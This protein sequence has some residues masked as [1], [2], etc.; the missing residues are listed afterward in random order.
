M[1]AHIDLEDDTPATGVAETELENEMEEIMK[2]VE[3]AKSMND[4]LRV[5]KHTQGELLK[6][7]DKDMDKL[8]ATMTTAKEARKAVGAR[9]MEHQMNLMDMLE[10]CQEQ[11]IDYTEAKALDQAQVGRGG[12]ASNMGRMAKA[13]KTK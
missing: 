9:F 13:L 6:K 12:T 7:L 5:H 1:P 11:G 10:L 3:K 2:E 8:E 4:A